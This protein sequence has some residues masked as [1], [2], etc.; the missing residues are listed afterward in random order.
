MRTLLAECSVPQ[1]RMTM[2]LKFNERNCF[3]KEFRL[4]RLLSRD[5]ENQDR[6]I[7]PCVTIMI[8]TNSFC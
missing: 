8:G 7:I 5:K 1:L 4:M 3:Q 2:G 6:D